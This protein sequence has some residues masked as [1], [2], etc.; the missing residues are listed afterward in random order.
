MVKLFIRLG[1]G[2]LTFNAAQ[3]VKTNAVV[4]R[5]GGSIMGGEVR[6]FSKGF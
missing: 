5:G 4:G 6:S 3:F 2:V 1:N